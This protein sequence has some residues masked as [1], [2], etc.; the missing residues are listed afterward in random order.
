MKADKNGLYIYEVNRK[1]FPLQSVALE[2]HIVSKLSRMDVCVV[3]NPLE[4]NKRDLECIN[5]LNF[6]EQSLQTNKVNIIVLCA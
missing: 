3:N 6:L 2:E 4:E 1:C 5:S